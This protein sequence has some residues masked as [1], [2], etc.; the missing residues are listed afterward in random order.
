[1]PAR[2]R[3]SVTDRLFREH[4]TFFRVRDRLQVKY[5]MLRAH[6]VEGRQVQAVRQAFG[7]SRQ[8]F[9]TLRTRF[10]ADG[11]EGL[12]PRPPGRLG[13]T[14]CT[15]EVMAFLRDAKTHDPTLSGA[16]LA[17]R[18]EERFGI[19]L[20]RRTVER[21]LGLRRRRPKKD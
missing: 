4:P 19:R 14:K 5:E 10:R 13:P 1:M 8:S 20:H 12:L 2:R 9:Y 6:A 3:P 7:F 21:V 16:T 15:A 17:A 18:V 11:L